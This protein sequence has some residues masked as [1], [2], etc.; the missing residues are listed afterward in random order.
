MKNIITVLPLFLSS[1]DK[2]SRERKMS[3][4]K[5]FFEC[6]VPVTACNIK[7][8]YCY[9]IQRNHRCMEI[10]K[11]KYS[12]QQIGKA[13]SVQRLGGVCYFSIYGAGETLLADQ[14]IELVE[15]LLK[16]GHFVNITTNGTLTKQFNRI[17]NFNKEYR[18]RLH[19]AFS[20]HYLELIRIK[21]LQT[22]FDN[23]KLM[24]DS[25]ISFLVQLNLCDE[26]EPYLEEIKECCKKNIGAYPQ[27]AAT[28]KEYNLN[29]HIELLTE[30]TKEE[31]INMGNTFNSP[32]FEFTMKNFNVKRSE[33]C[34]AGDWSGV[35]N[36]QTG[37]LRK[38][39][40]DN[41]GQNIFDNPEKPVKWEAIGKCGS[42]F[43]MNSSHF[44]SLGIIP[45][46][47]ENITYAGLRNRE[48]AGWYTLDVL[49]ALN[50]KLSETNDIYTNRR[51][52]I[53]LARA[54]I[55]SCCKNVKK[56]IKGLI[57][58]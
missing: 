44:M 54:T 16:Q 35:L 47:Y 49:K 30:H 1:Q 3:Q 53:I 38:C 57:K 18:D 33:F 2:E 45:E 51:K 28:R 14:I 36:L 15:E 48:E 27:V 58:K 31:Y 32:L 7:C 10:P 13:L 19:I 17:S 20:F 50:G 46:C 29:Q 23:V 40:S 21:K 43:C 25:G 12:I 34:Y 39:Y 5:R 11:L 56:Y 6:L 8:S 52:N 37:I 22:F 41:G 55:H 26:Y 9:I 4:I 24:K 42:L